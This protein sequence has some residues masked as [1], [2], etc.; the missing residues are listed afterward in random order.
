VSHLLLPV[1]RQANLDKWLIEVEQQLH[2]RLSEAIPASPRPE[3]LRRRLEHDDQA[4]SDYIYNTLAGYLDEL[5]GRAFEEDSGWSA[6]EVHNQAERFR[7]RLV[8]KVARARYSSPLFDLEEHINGWER[9]IDKSHTW[10]VFLGNMKVLA[11]W[12][13]TDKNVSL[14]AKNLAWLKTRT[15]IGFDAIAAKVGTED[16]K[17]VIA[18]IKGRRRPGIK[19]IEEYADAF[20]KA[21]GQKITADDIR[22]KDIS[23]V[24]R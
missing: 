7:A 5:T 23:Q 17:A 4:Y 13:P 22:L 2:T 18:H 15:G 10:Q 24:V 21:L 20:S 14:V 16:K 19:K 6:A 3:A 1:S 11:E 9:T 12:R 8:E